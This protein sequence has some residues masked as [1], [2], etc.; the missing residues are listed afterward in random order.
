VTYTGTVVGTD[1]TAGNVSNSSTNL[2]YTDV[3]ASTP[4]GAT[5]INAGD[6]VYVVWEH[7]TG[8]TESSVPAGF[9]QI[10]T[11]TDGSAVTSVYERVCAGGE[12]GSM[13][14][15][16]AS[17]ISRMT[18]TVT[19]VRGYSATNSI[20][21]VVD[22][23][24]DANHTTPAATPSV[25]DV[26]VLIAVGNR[27]A[28]GPTAT[29]PPAGYTVAVQQSTD[30]TNRT[31]AAMAYEGS[32]GNITGTHTSGVA[33]NPGTFVDNVA[34][35]DCVVVTIL[36]TPNL[37]VAAVT[38]TTETDTVVTVR[39][40]KT[41]ASTVATETDAA[42]VV[43][44]VKSRPQTPTT[45]ADTVV[46]LGRV[47]ARSLTPAT[48]TDT[49]TAQARSKTRA[50]AVTTEAD[51]AG[52]GWGDDGW[53]DGAW[54]GG[55]LRSHV[56]TLTPATET[57]TVVATGRRKA[58]TLTPSGE[59]DSALTVD[60]DVAGVTIVSLTPALEADGAVT[61]GRTKTKA[62]TPA[63]ETDTAV[64][65]GRRRLAVL[66]PATESDAA[67]LLGVRKTRS[68]PSAA[69]ADAATSL[70]PVR[71]VT[72]TP[73]V[74]IETARPLGRLRAYELTPADESNAALLLTTLRGHTL[75]PAEETDEA[76]AVVAAHVALRDITVSAYLL[77]RTRTAALVERW[78]AALRPRSRRAVLRP[79]DL[80]ATLVR[81]WKAHL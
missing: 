48:E 29:T 3:I 42:Q 32:G 60:R 38:P 7:S 66:N 57:D 54:G 25:A 4:S 14:A 71:V 65:L 6:R 41:R 10:D 26:G 12:T 80:D 58:R 68:L 79:R 59:V 50:L 28:T 24:T 49:A 34:S 81:R 77:P 67:T 37:T 36:L 13:G 78:E 72:I 2:S 19:V 5:A 46:A 22:T 21:S 27:I 20:V 56:R 30:V 75:T 64:V 53:G 1:S 31:F 51:I 55:L 9:T 62:L 69:E 39:R 18:W 16:T 33:I 15:F 45:E 52:A 40:S 61:I 11:R 63:V 8:V 23:G 47:K 70:N 73:A 76:W 43:G 35:S 44:R 74:E 17:A